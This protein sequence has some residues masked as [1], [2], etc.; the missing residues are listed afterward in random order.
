MTQEKPLFTAFGPMSIPVQVMPSMGFLLL[1]FVGL[2]GGTTDLIWG[3]GMFGILVVSIFLH[4]LGHAWGAHVQG[5]KVHRIVL[6]GGGGFCEHRSAGAY[7]SELIVLM[8]PLVNLALWAALS[9][10]ATGLLP[11]FPNMDMSDEAI[12]AFFAAHAARFEVIFWLEVAAEIN[13]MLFI[14]NMIPVQP[15]DGGKLLHLWLLRVVPQDTALLLTGGL[16]LICA[17]LW[18]PLM[19]GVYYY[20]GFVLLFL[21]SL[22][23]HWAMVRGATRMRRLDRR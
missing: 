11:S 9:L 3:I 19:I 4:E 12:D 22:R 1:V 14:L 8:G 5:I 2:T 15:L 13:L 6:H 7:A 10:L 23:I 17:V 18:V 16:G 20:V 21:P